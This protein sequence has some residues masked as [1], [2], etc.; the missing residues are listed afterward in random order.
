MRL[1]KIRND[2][3]VELR[4]GERTSKLQEDWTLGTM[5]ILCY[6]WSCMMRRQGG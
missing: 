3:S 4:T 5:E 6:S 1:V 2:K